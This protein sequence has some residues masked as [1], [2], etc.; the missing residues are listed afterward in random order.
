MPTS[1]KFFYDNAGAAYNP[2][3]ETEHQGKMRYARKLASAEKR[4]CE[5]G[6]AFR[7]QRDDESGYW[8]LWECLMYSP[9]GVVVKSLHA[10]DFGE[11][12]SPWGN[13]YRRVVQAE[14]AL[15]HF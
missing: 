10:I 2:A 11:D 7:W 13:S 3:T 12:G 4:A 9:A 1:L 8:S 15:E 14:L 6:Y 5:E